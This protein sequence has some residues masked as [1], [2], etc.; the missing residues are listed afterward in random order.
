[1]DARE[2]RTKPNRGVKNADLVFGQVL[3]NQA[4]RE[5]IAQIL[6]SG[7]REER[8]YVVRTLFRRTISLECTQTRVSRESLAPMLSGI[9]WMRFL[10]RS[11]TFTPYGPEYDTI[12]TAPCASHNEPTQHIFLQR[13]TTDACGLVKKNRGDSFPLSKSTAC[14]G[15]LQLL[16]IKGKS[17]IITASAV[18]RFSPVN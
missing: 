18:R 6:K 11:T 2:D 9:R 16:K 8:Q 4:T 13:L 5:I 3:Q 15:D 14:S 12:V 10:L 17:H 1:L 7:L